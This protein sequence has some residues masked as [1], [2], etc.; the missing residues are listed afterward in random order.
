M[1]DVVEFNMDALKKRITE[2][3]QANFGMLI[4]QD[5]FTEM[6]NKE[7][8]AFF[9]VDDL[10]LFAS[11]ER[12][13]E[14]GWSRHSFIEN[15]KVKCTPFRL[16][17][18]MEVHKIIEK[19]LSATFN[20]PKFMA[21][22]GYDNTAQTAQLS[23]EMDKK[24]QAMAPKMMADLIKNSFAAMVNQAKFEIMESLKRNI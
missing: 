9:E 23:E 24:L 3:V 19:Q 2:Q 18:W 6:V 1:G 15:W 14:G 4:P 16:L 11:T 20:D 13:E 10:Q 7:I 12:R 22:T 21:M 5:K 8:K 17:V